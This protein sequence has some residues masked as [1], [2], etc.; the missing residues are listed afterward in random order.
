M[1]SLDRYRKAT[2]LGEG[3]Y[4][5]VYKAIDTQTSEIVAIKRIRLEHEEEGVPGTAIREISLLKELSHPNIVQ[6]KQVLHHQHRLHLIFEYCE[7]DLKKLLDTKKL[8]NPLIKSLLQEIISS[9]NYCHARRIL[10]RDLKPQN[11]LIHADHAKLADFGL[12]RTF[13]IPVRQFTH[14]IVTLWYRPPEIL[15]NTRHYSTAVDVWSIGCIWCEMLCNSTPLFPGDSEI[16]QLFKIF[17]VLGTPGVPGKWE[18][19]RDLPDFKGNFPNFKGVGLRRI[20]GA[21]RLS[22]NGWD[23]L[24]KMLEMDPVARISCKDAMGHCYWGEDQGGD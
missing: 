17:E 8:S 12:A 1:S 18:S 23:L 15:L 24:E 5:E 22:E 21:E 10:H 7:T 4:G 3:T 14:E 11:I 6:L 2:K 9:T 19:A 16:D 13:G 20:L